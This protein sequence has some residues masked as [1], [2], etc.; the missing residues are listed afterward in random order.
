MGNA[1]EQWDISLDKTALTSV[2]SSDDAPDCASETRRFPSEPMA[3]V[4]YELEIAAAVRA[5]YSLVEADSPSDAWRAQLARAS[6]MKLTFCD[7]RV[8]RVQVRKGPDRGAACS[9]LLGR[10]LRAP[11]GQA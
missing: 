3:Q 11:V 2:L 8:D 9:H 1:H 7:E 5:G 6:A 10:L 4:A